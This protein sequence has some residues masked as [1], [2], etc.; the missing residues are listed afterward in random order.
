MGGVVGVAFQSA[1]MSTWQACAAVFEAPAVAS[2]AG[3]VCR[4]ADYV[5]VVNVLLAV[6]GQPVAYA[7]VRSKG[8]NGTGPQPRCPAGS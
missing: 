1:G 3:E 4:T 6:D 8:A 2:K 7:I 5:L